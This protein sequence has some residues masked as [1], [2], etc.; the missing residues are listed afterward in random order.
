MVRQ[1]SSRE[2]NTALVQEPGQ[3]PVN[4]VVRLFQLKRWLHVSLLR[5]GLSARRSER[6]TPKP[7]RRHR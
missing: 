4:S 3:R 7:D 5:P 1:R 2:G 6:H